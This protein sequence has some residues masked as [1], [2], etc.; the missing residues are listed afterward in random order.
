ALDTKTKWTESDSDTSSTR[1]A[2]GHY[3]PNRPTLPMTTYMQP[4]K[5]PSAWMFATV[6]GLGLALASQ[7]AHAM[8]LSGVITVNGQETE[9]VIIA[10]YDCATSVLLASTTTGPT[11][12]IGGIASNYRAQVASEDVRVELFFQDDP[13]DVLLTDYCRAFIFCGQIVPVNGIG[14]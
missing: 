1:M 3:N 4:R 13:T 2:R 12:I 10:V 11:E 14:V 9:G 7:T 5:Q 8:D 6:A